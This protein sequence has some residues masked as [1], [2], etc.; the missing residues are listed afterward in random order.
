L[1][2]GWNRRGS[3]R[4][5]G[6]VR[7]RLGSANGANRNS[8]PCSGPGQRRPRGLSFDNRK[9]DESWNVLPNYDQGRGSMGL[10]IQ[11]ELGF[12]TGSLRPGC[13]PCNASSLSTRATWRGFFIALA[14][15]R[16][17]S[18]WRGE[19]IPPPRWGPPNISLSFR[20]FDRCLVV[21]PPLGPAFV[22]IAHV[23]TAHQLQRER[24]NRRAAAGLAISRAG[25]ARVDAGILEQFR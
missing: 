16:P 6:G 11:A 20:L 9:R 12:S 13:F 1:N 21:I 25:L 3:T 22:V 8:A 2:W 4:H 18:G 15:W 5:P 17:P 24:Q 23:L 19:L 14:V 10:V 7:R